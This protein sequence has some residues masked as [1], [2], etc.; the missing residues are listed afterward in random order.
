MDCV[1]Y[2]VVQYFSWYNFQFSFVYI[3]LIINIML[4]A[5]GQRKIHVPFELFQG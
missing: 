5:P 1:R 3:A 4:H 2:V